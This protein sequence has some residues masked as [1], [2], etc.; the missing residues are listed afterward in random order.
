VLFRAVQEA[1]T[2]VVR[3]AH[4]T[5]VTVTLT[6]RPDGVHLTVKDDG[7]GFDTSGIGAPSSQARASGWGLVGMRERVALA[8]G[9]FTIQ[10]QLGHGTLVIVELP[11][12]RAGNLKQEAG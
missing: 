9:H 5:L 6:Q 10:S 7:V 12:H 1:L 2:N 11:L 4:A 8:G 3:H